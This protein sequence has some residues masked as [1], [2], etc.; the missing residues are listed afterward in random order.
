LIIGD[1]H[2]EKHSKEFDYA[3]K[4][5]QFLD[6]HKIPKKTVEDARNLQL[7]RTKKNPNKLCES[8]ENSF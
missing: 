1:N 3:E 4:A 7:E 6:R 2:H 8:L 5:Y